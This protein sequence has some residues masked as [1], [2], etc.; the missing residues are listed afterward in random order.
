MSPE[1]Q[2]TGFEQVYLDESAYIE[3]RRRTLGDM[4]AGEPIPDAPTTDANLVGLALSGGGVRS[5]TVSLGAL[6]ALARY[7][8]FKHVDYLSTVSG[9]GFL[10]AAI[11]SRMARQHQPHQD[12]PTE[13]EGDETPPRPKPGTFPLDVGDPEGTDAVRHMRAHASYLTPSGVQDY[14][15]IVAVLVRG[16][17]LNLM[18]MVPFLLLFCALSLVVF[19]QRLAD[20]R[21][22]DE[23]VER[24]TVMLDRLYGDAP[25]GERFVDPLLDE[26]AQRHMLADGKDE[27]DVLRALRG[28]VDDT[29]R[30]HRPLVHGAG[31][32]ALPRT[33]LDDVTTADVARR[34]ME[35]QLLRDLG[36]IEEIYLVAAELRSL[37]GD[38]DWT[39][40]HTDMLLDPEGPLLADDVDADV[41]DRA[42]AWTVSELAHHLY[43]SEAIDRDWFVDRLYPPQPAWDLVG[44]GT[45]FSA[46]EPDG[47]DDCLMAQAGCWV[48][49]GACPV[50]RC[51]VP[52]PGEVRTEYERKTAGNHCHYLTYGA[53]EADY[54]TRVGA[55]AGFMAWNPYRLQIRFT[56]ALAVAMFLWVLMYPL[57]GILQQV[58]RW[59]LSNHDDD[60]LARLDT[61]RDRYEGTFGWFLVLLAI[62]FLLELLPYAVYHFHT[63][64]IPADSDLSLVVSAVSLVV[65][66]LGGPLLGV[67]RQSSRWLLV[68]ALAL[69]VP[70]LPTL[71]YL[72]A[73][74]AIV[75]SE[76]GGLLY[77][78]PGWDSVWVTPEVHPAH[79]LALN[80]P[81][82]VVMLLSMG[83]TIL[84][85]G[86]LLDVNSTSL[87]AFYRDR[88]GVA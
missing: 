50:R 42:G 76:P 29:S 32:D 75:W 56:E 35:R 66:A 81:W 27:Q 43:E 31:T 17:V 1:E 70:A 80:R 69:I 47:A 37:T 18:V 21:H 34:L 13:E 8:V 79:G 3:D 71:A 49:D 61:W 7:G 41:F 12:D 60:G 38:G 82:A 46:A 30:S 44:R 48:T 11:T 6:Q 14:P 86:L 25:D 36:E 5:A 84:A 62:V 53:S 59:R 45:C 55:R 26:F 15:R 64:R 65:G 63:I 78:L 4:R 22:D 85:G 33:F 51:Y 39:S 57:F 74:D 28:L 16:M 23:L 73:M 58:E 87:H 9:G 67:L 72:T 40:V 24:A 77:S 10:G 52:A 54:A 88:L 2:P 19:G 20:R 83:A 68:L